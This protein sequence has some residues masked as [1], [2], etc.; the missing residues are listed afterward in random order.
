MVIK[1]AVMGKDGVR[2][3][4][5]LDDPTTQLEYDLHAWQDTGRPVFV[6]T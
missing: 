4:D 3:G 5:T 1:T 6:H 2:E